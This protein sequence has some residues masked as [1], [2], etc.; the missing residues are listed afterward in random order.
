MVLRY[1]QYNILISTRPTSII[2][3]DPANENAPYK[4]TVDIS[5][6][7]TLEDVMNVY[8]LGPNGGNYSTYYKS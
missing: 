7:I 8:S 1:I 2:N 6:L 4:A 5:E 3:L